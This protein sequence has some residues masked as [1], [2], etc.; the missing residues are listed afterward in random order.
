MVSN[1]AILG[2]ECAHVHTLI[3]ML[4]TQ[5]AGVKHDIQIYFV[6]WCERFCKWH[7]PVENRDL[8]GSHLVFTSHSQAS[9]FNS[10]IEYC[11]FFVNFYV[12]FLYCNLVKNQ[13]KTA[14]ALFYLYLNKCTQLEHME[15]LQTSGHRP[16]S[17]RF[18]F[19][20]V[21]CPT[22]ICFS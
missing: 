1:E 22:K 16:S 11:R 12:D 20:Q 4:T 5:P 18:T 7:F 10:E 2:K 13:I 3:C 17:L 21:S 8:S 6:N 19:L 14:G 9:D 15:S